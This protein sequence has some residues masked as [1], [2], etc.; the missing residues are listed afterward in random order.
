MLDPDV[1]KL[2]TR[3]HRHSVLDRFDRAVAD[4]WRRANRPAARAASR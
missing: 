3:S 4:A 2:H 1:L